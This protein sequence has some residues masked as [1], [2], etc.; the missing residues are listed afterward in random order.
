MY[1]I[2]VPWSTMQIS[3]VNGECVEWHSHGPPDRHPDRRNNSNKEGTVS[4]S[5]MNSPDIHR[6]THTHTYIA[7]VWD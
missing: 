1:D 5:V 6:R 2:Q 4:R 7:G 3:V